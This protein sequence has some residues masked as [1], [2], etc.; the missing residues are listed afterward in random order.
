MLFKGEKKAENTNDTH[1]DK[2]RTHT[3]KGHRQYSEIIRQISQIKVNMFLLNKII[4]SFFI[5]ARVVVN[6]EL[7]LEY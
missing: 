7:F 4:G 3:A 1:M 6:K 5:L 2:G